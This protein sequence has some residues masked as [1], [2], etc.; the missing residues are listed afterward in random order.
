MPMIFK[1]SLLRFAKKSEGWSSDK[2]LLRFFCEI[3]ASGGA[4]ECRGKVLSSS[5]V[6]K[7]DGWQRFSLTEQ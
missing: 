3:G 5:Y 4:R 1:E 7:Q 6:Y 2:I